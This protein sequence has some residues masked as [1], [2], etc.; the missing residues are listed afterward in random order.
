[1]SHRLKS[2]KILVIG[3]ILLS[4]DL[5]FSL[6]V[7]PLSIF[8]H[9]LGGLLII[10]A[11]YGMLPHRG[12][13]GAA[14]R[15]GVGF[16][17]LLE[18]VVK[19]LEDLGKV[20]QALDDQL[21]WSDGTMGMLDSLAT[22][23]FACALILFA[24][25]MQYRCTQE[26]LS[27]LAKRWRQAFAR[28]LFCYGAAAVIFAIST[29]IASLHSGDGP[30]AGDIV[31]MAIATLS[32]V[33]SN[34][35]LFYVIRAFA[36]TAKA[37]ARPAGRQPSVAARMVLH[38][39]GAILLLVVLLYPIW[40]V[41]VMGI[42]MQILPSFDEFV[43]NHPDPYILPALPDHLLALP[44]AT[45]HGSYREGERPNPENRENNDDR[46]EA[47]YTA[48]ISLSH[49]DER[50]LDLEYESRVDLN[51]ETHGIAG[52]SIDPA[53]ITH[54][55]RFKLVCRTLVEANA[56]VEPSGPEGEEASHY[57]LEYPFRIELALV[58]G[59]GEPVF[60]MVRVD[61]L[62]RHAP[63]ILDEMAPLLSSG[64]T[65]HVAPDGRLK[66]PSMAIIGGMLNLS[67]TILLSLL[68]VADLPPEGQGMRYRW[69]VSGRL[70]VGYFTKHGGY[71]GG[72]SADVWFGLN[73]QEYSHDL[74]FE[75][76]SKVSR[77]GGSS[78]TTRKA[79]SNL[80]KTWNE[81][82]W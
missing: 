33:F 44:A 27:D 63:P 55:P 11:C 76:R 9:L 4:L 28:S 64:H 26:T 43:V 68:G 61:G 10:S 16:L 25:G 5:N 19:I 15:H 21:A 73:S 7:I 14:L 2:P 34:L 35:P 58:S 1:V 82:V 49:G 3:A 50:L 20:V 70:N 17:V 30:W 23:L 78:T 48:S 18:L 51:T 40:I 37:S 8:T 75:D 59:Q 53:R 54:D 13:N 47:G 66:K 71:S 65:D 60:E 29:T 36:D 42:H 69:T 74:I 24:R 38:P 57:R 6:G 56:T 22:V 45:V 67:K 72:S 31:S 46:L 41:L 77:G 79:T 80:I 12:E 39:W 52:L 32:I 62:D 81:R